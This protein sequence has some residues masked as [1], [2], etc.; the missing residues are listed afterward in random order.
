M[1]DLFVEYKD[2]TENIIKSI[3]N[4]DF[5]LLNKLLENRDII[6]KK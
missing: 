4:E 6:I 5:D 3:E 1:Y 2:I